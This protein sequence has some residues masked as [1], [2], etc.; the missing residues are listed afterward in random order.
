[1]RTIASDFCAAVVKW[2]QHPAL[3]IGGCPVELDTAGWTERDHKTCRASRVT[4]DDTINLAG[5]DFDST[6][7]KL[8]VLWLDLLGRQPTQK[9]DDFFALGGHSLMTAQLAWRIREL[10]A[11]DV[12]IADLQRSSQLAEMA[13]LIELAPRY[14]KR[15]AVPAPANRLT[16]V[17]GLPCQLELGSWT[18]EQLE[19][20]LAD[21]A[22]ASACDHLHRV[23]SAFLGT[24][25]QFESRRPLPLGNCLPIRLGT[26]DCFTFV[27]TTIALAASR[28]LDEFARVLAVLRYK[29]L[30]AQ[31]I[32]SDP[33]T[34][35]IF[36]F[37]EEALL[38]NAVER[39]L[40][41]DVTR[42]IGAGV[43]LEFVQ[44]RLS[45]VRR[46]AAMDPLELWATPKLGRLAISATFIPRVA[47]GLFDDTAA[48]RNGDIVLMSRGGSPGGQIIDHLGLVHIEDG[49][50]H[51]LQS[52]R[53]YA[54]HPAPGPPPQNGE[55]T[56]IFY[57]EEKRCEQIGVGIGGSYLGDEFTLYQ[58]DLPLFGYRRGERR[59]LSDYL[60]G[61]FK[62]A[63][64]LRPNF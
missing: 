33:E 46:T 49:R 54:H 7:L 60:Q 51:L 39:G 28:D 18:L 44:T 29:E 14:V 53:H 1:M 43:E 10:F 2:L 57:D 26:F 5:G 34:G 41:I 36:D 20:L 19:D 3:G 8:A 12:R 9:N 24:P 38:A 58:G 47:F 35:T 15:S 52:T 6:E 62:R 64:V 21:R 50:T 55:Y 22:G 37:A 11:A 42:E 31:G 4:K 17:G 30:L 27:L 63:L 45:P 48:L 13:R 25:F 56:G 16:M 23:A 32:D 40:L 59:L 61:A